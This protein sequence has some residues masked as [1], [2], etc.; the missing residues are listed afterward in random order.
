VLT[1]RVFAKLRDPITFLHEGKDDVRA[2]AS[3]QPPKG[4][5][6]FQI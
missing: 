2:R 3:R 4:S 6:M 5:D 1:V